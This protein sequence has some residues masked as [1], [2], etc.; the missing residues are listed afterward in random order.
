MLLKLKA[1]P[2]FCSAISCSTVEL[3][4][5]GPFCSCRGS[6]GRCGEI[7][8][9]TGRLFASRNC[10][11]VPMRSIFRR[12]LS[13]GATFDLCLSRWMVRPLFSTQAREG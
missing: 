3:M 1:G 12:F 5:F 13:F 10:W 8:R 2:S 7:A 11:G 9:L 4:S 6:C